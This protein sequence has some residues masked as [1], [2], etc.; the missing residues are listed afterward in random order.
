MGFDH[1]WTHEQ[2]YKCVVDLDTVL[3]EMK[4]LT[5]ENTQLSDRCHVSDAKVAATARSLENVRAELR[6]QESRR[7]TSASE[8]ITLRK[9]NVKAEAQLRMAR[10]DLEQTRGEAL[11]AK[12]ELF[13]VRSE[14]DGLRKENAELQKSSSIAQNRVIVLEEERQCLRTEQAHTGDNQRNTIEQLRDARAQLQ[15]FRDLAQDRLNEVETLKAHLDESTRQ[16]GTLRVEARRPRTG[17]PPVQ[18]SVVA[19]QGTH[20]VPASVMPGMNI[21]KLQSELRRTIESRDS[22]RND[23]AILLEARGE[24]SIENQ[25]SVGT[26]SSS[27]R[28]STKS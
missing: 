5:R 21:E 19:T 28:Q 27:P 2:R 14:R 25:R 18:H 20:S 7:S 3:S 26:P 11:S 13:D 4:R 24:F 1:E 9:D 15:N 16:I 12:T 10:N 22:L 8:M 17:P 6:S 23:L